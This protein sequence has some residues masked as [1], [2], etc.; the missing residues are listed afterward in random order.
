MVVTHQLLIQA[1]E[2][3]SREQ[4]EGK[5]IDINVLAK[6]FKCPMADLIVLLY[7]LE[8]WKIVKLNI[9]SDGNIRNTRNVN[10]YKVKREVT[11]L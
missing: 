1:L 2:D 6:Y 11:L 7:E 4:G 10:P 9:Q 3:L 5:P 8:K